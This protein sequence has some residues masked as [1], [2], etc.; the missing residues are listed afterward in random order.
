MVVVVVVA[1]CG[2]VRYW[3]AGTSRVKVEE[4]IIPPHST[5]DNKFC[6]ALSHLQHLL[7]PTV[8]LSLGLRSLAISNH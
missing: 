5:V 6:S 7:L 1:M 3:S 4:A 8:E 2:M